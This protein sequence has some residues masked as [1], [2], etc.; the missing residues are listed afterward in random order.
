[1]N[2][3]ININLRSIEAFKSISER[4]LATI[5]DQFELVNYSLGF[6][7]CN[8]DTIPDKILIILSGEARLLDGT[9]IRC[10]TISKLKSDSFIGLSSFLRAKGCELVAASSDLLCL[11]LSDKIILEL[12]KEE[13]TFRH[14]CNTHIQKADILAIAKTL[15]A[16]IAKKL[17]EKVGAAEAKLAEAKT[18]AMANLNDVAAEAAMAAVA[19]L[20]GVKASSAQAR[21][22]A[23]SI[24]T[25]LAKQETN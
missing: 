8:K 7:I 12:Y 21:K 25:K 19:S 15:D 23:S 10:S 4:G 1:M 13:P 3:N 6:P 22:T 9:N 24:A 16:K 11:A 14:W 5:E 20:A 17:A 18:S 2:S